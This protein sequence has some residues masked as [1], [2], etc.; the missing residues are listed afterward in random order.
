MWRSLVGGEQILYLR[1]NKYAH[2]PV[3][4]PDGCQ[5]FG[6]IERRGGGQVGREARVV[7]LEQFVECVVKIVLRAGTESEYELERYVP[8]KRRPAARQHA[9]VQ[10]ARVR[11]S[12]WSEQL[13]QRG[14]QLERS[15]PRR[16]R[17]RADRHRNRLRLGRGLLGVRVGQERR[18]PEQLD[19]SAAF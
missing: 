5:L 6:V 8:R 4:E 19:D 12:V 9:Q 14:F 11:L 10:R 13:L 3:G 17:T 1:N 15:F 2:L 7:Q 18:P 16:H